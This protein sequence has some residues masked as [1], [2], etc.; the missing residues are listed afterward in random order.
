MLYSSVKDMDAG[1]ALPDC[2]NAVL[3]LWKHAT[4]RIA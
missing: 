1:H 2:F 3:K 4:A